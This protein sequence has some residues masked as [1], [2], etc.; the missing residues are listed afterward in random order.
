MRH[1]GICIGASTISLVELSGN[2]KAPK[3]E[4]V[5]LR[6]HE[7]NARKVL[8]ETLNE[9][10]ISAEDSIA[11][12]G[13]KFRNFINLSSITEPEAVE[14]AYEFASRGE[15]HRGIVSAGGETFMVYSLDDTGKIS[16][17]FTGNKCASGTGEFFLQQIRRMD[18]TIDDAMALADGNTPHKVA[19]RCSVFC[20]S[21]CTHALN[22]GE[23]KGNVVAGLCEMIAGKI[24]ELLTKVNSD[25]IMVVGGTSQNSIVMGYLKSELPNIYIPPEAPYFEALGAALWSMENET[26][27]FPGYEEFYRHGES[28]FTF[29]PPLKE[30][31]SLVTF[32]ELKFA[33]ICN[34][35][36]AIIGLDV[37]ST[38]TKAVILRTSDNAIAASVYLRTNGNPIDASRKCYAELAK[39]APSGLKIIGL[40]V[41]GSGRQIAG[42]HALTN[43]VINEIIAHATAAVYF[44]STV[45]TIFE[46]GGQ[47]AKYTYITSG[48]PSDYAMNEA[49]SAGTGSFLEEAAKESLGINVTEIS[50]IAMRANRPPN[51]NDQCAAFIS[52]DIKNAAHEG[53]PKEDV[54][55]GLVY[56]ICM[57]YANRVK[58]NRPYGNKIFMQGGVCYNRS[59]PIA[60]AALIGK[61]IIVPPEPGLMGAFGVALELKNRIN[62]GLSERQ[63]FSLSELAAREVEYGK[64]FRCK[65]GKEKCDRNCEIS[66]ILIKGQKYPFGGAC[67]KYYNMRYNIE[68]DAEKL[69]LVNLRQRLLL[70]KYAADLHLELPSDVPTIG[71]NRSFLANSLFPLYFNFFTKL[72]MRVIMPDE[73]DDKGIDK[74]GAAFCFPVEIAHGLFQNLINKKPDFIFLPH[75]MEI[76]SDDGPGYKKNCVF[77]QAE[78]F[79]LKTTF[80]KELAEIK[81]LTPKISFHDGLRAQEKVFVEIANELGYGVKNAIVAYDYAC[82]RQ[83]EYQ[84]EARQIGGEA[85]QQLRRSPDEFAVV[86]F[87]RPY[88]SF[89][90][91]ANMGIPH[92]FA[93]RGVKIIP[94]DFLPLDRNFTD[95]TMYW[96]TGRT[97]LAAS[98]FI[99]KD[100]QL[101]G[102]FITNFSCG[103]DSFIIT[104]FRDIM[105]KKPSLTLEIDYHTA[106]AGLNT[107]I[108]AFLDIIRRYRELE[109]NNKIPL[110]GDHFIPAE[111]V[112]KGN[113]A[114]ITTAKGEKIP[115]KD[116]RVRV[117]IPSMGDLGAEAFS[118]AIRSLGI[119]SVPLPMPDPEA[120]RIGR[121]A[122]TCKE[123]LP[124]LLTAGSVLKYVQDNHR[125]GEIIVYFMPKSTGPCR[126]GQYNVYL[127]KFIRKNR[128]PDVAV[129]TLSDDNSYAG[130]GS[131]FSYRAWQAIVI[132]DVMEDIRQAILVMAKEPEMAMDIFAQEW[133][134][135]LQAIERKNGVS[136][137]KQLHSSAKRLNAI[138]KK[139]P[140]S[141]A[142]FVAIIG[143]IYVRRDALSRQGL[144][145]YLA[146]RGFISRIAPVG[147]YIYYS[148]YLLKHKLSRVKLTFLEK[149]DYR[150]K[151]FFQFRIESKFKK[152]LAH[153]GFYEYETIDVGKTVEHASHLI[154]P[155]MAGESILTVGLGLREIISTA[156]GV[157]SIGPFG[158]MPS[159]VAESILSQEMNVEGLSRLNGHKKHL[160]ANHLI[161][162]LPFLAIE[163][164]GQA[165]PQIIQAKLETFCLQADRVHEKLFSNASAT[166]D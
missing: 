2:G 25:K 11:I 151:D 163:S 9:V 85:L 157:I 155:Y 152:I 124:M 129:L 20:K 52:S 68:Y 161:K 120:L 17:V 7:G 83:E 91:E 106:D 6:A 69:D 53:I 96:G 149:L 80:R 10:Q 135:I 97:L 105:G 78:P 148:H 115:L 88:N 132:S 71:I 33:R 12:T 57:N 95:E 63:E 139:Y 166:V 46:I 3:I 119:H 50:E 145:D 160:P 19:G 94:F 37:G 47:D 110:A 74:K 35:E 67:N 64:T 162:D 141:E 39:Q 109:R 13:R 79:Y 76:D 30:Y 54:V 153:S 56:S 59:V 34:G 21:D 146:Q 24:S 82:S 22:K 99:K 72:G 70:G 137:E 55:A 116:P 142:K 58:G 111:V 1:F 98:D 29:H 133:K 104:Y 103:P 154:S 150:F 134:R 138:P 102:A 159:R 41:T 28:A 144:T 31:E 38:T 122:T 4:H 8:E 18:L 26:I 128:L 125:E 165:F 108:E 113:E 123:C 36:E 51:F 48:V 27:P 14:K 136:V 75:V 86:L 90:K 130:L 112:I 118:A 87:G 126:F 45:D 107:R 42:L 60:M 114:C 93:S 84:N 49:C 62:L 32:K 156:C 5:I 77:I 73:V 23:P 131:K 117:L 164:D 43:G 65:G 81:V 15:K 66:M 143:E 61:E 121:G 140:I 158:C 127:R 92:K 147:E 44:D 100:P 16:N 101:Y 40:G 89:A